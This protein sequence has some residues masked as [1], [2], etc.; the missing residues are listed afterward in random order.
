M[1][2]LFAG[3]LI[4][5][6]YVLELPMHALLHDELIYSIVAQEADYVLAG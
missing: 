1:L 5:R 6:A 2:G 4:Y 3:M